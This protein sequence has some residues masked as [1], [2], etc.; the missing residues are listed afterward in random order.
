[1]MSIG[2][3]K[4][5]YSF[6]LMPGSPINLLGR[7]L[8]CKLRATIT[9]SPDGSMSL[10]LPEESLALLPVLLSDSHEMK[11]S[12]TFK[13]PD[14]IPECLWA[15]SSFD[16]DLLKLVVPVQI[17]IKCSLPHSIPQYPLSKEAIKGIIPV[18]D[19][20]LNRK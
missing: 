2:P 5:E 13:I 9:C 1:M 19:S 15:T 12:P 17:K 3:L 18:I 7:Y 4:V 10:E 20:L 6:L 16:I 11:E 14:D 8:L